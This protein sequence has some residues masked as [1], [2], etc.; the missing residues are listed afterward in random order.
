MDTITVPE[1]F[2]TIRDKELEIDRLK[3]WKFNEATPEARVKAA[4]DLKQARRDL[5][6]MFDEITAD[7]IREYGKWVGIPTD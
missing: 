4:D 5:Y 6:K 1:S 2:R 7:E 3:H